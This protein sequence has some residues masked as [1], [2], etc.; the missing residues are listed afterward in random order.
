MANR[1]DGKSQLGVSLG[2]NWEM[3]LP[4]ESRWTPEVDPASTSKI[5]WQKIAVDGKSTYLRETSVRETGRIT[6]EKAVALATHSSLV[7]LEHSP[8]RSRPVSVFQTFRAQTRV[9]GLDGA[10]APSFRVDSQ[11]AGGSW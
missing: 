1:V 5:P 10:D 3:I 4:T 7:L 2:R 6:A 8:S 11:W 9:H